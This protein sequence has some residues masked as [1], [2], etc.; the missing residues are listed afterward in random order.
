MRYL[1]LLAVVCPAGALAQGLESVAPKQ[2]VGLYP[3]KGIEYYCTDGHG[4]RVELG[5]VIC[6]TASCQTWMARCE[7]AANNNLA[8]WRKMQDGCPGASLYLRLKQLHPPV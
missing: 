5:E 2:A 6:V 1:L 4:E 7:M 3:D 8:M